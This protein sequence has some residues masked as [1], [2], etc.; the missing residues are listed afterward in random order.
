[1]EKIKNKRRVYMTPNVVPSH[2]KPFIFASIF[3]EIFM[4]YL[5][6]LPETIL[7]GS[8]RQPIL[9]NMFLDSF[10]FGSFSRNQKTTKNQKIPKLQ[11]LQKIQQLNYTIY[12]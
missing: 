1:M 5:N 12:T 7:V 6:P 3:H 9:Q 2:Q 11:H 10:I 8:K 4:F